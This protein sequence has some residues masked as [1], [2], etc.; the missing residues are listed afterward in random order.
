MVAKARINVAC[1]KDTTLTGRWAMSTQEHENGPRTC[2]LFYNDEIPINWVEFADFLASAYPKSEEIIMWFVYYWTDK[3][4][5]NVTLKL[6]G[7]AHTSSSEEK[8][9]IIT[10][11]AEKMASVKP[12]PAYKVQEISVATKQRGLSSLVG[13]WKKRTDR[14]RARTQ[15]KK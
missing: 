2:D 5:T 9:A 11:N 1:W 6:A 10:S 7:T 12:P 4:F 8:Q 13:C 15:G 14:T 3:A